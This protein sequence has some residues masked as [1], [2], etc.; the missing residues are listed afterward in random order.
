MSEITIKK[1]TSMENSRKLDRI[2][3]LI[4]GGKATTLTGRVKS[5]G[6]LT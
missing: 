3:Q 5:G 4:E 1:G 6:A 2:I